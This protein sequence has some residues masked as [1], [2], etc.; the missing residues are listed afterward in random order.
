MDTSSLNEHKI[1]LGFFLTK[2]SIW[3]SNRIMLMNFSPE[4]LITVV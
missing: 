4:F 2:E 1:V 3:K